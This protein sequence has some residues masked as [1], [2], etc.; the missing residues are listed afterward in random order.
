MGC[1]RES[2]AAVACG[3]AEKGCWDARVFFGVR[4]GVCTGDRREISDSRVPGLR[5]VF[6][7][8]F[9]A[10]FLGLRMLASLRGVKGLLLDLPPLPRGLFAVGLGG[11]AGSTS[12]SSDEEE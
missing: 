8:T 6:L 4:D 1:G 3:E 5:F 10:L 2:E 7:Q 12:I 9:P 11:L